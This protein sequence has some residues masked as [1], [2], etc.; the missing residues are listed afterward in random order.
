LDDIA[1]S[2]DGEML[3]ILP[4]ETV[5]NINKAIGAV[6]NYATAIEKA[7]QETA[8]LVKAKKD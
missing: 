2:A 4:P 7:T 1:K 3:D 8:E 5:A 6:Q